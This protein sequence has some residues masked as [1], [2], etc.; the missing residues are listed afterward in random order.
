MDTFL[1]IAEEAA[2]NAGGQYRRSI[3]EFTGSHWR[4]NSNALKEHST[5]DFQDDQ[6]KRIFKSYITGRNGNMKIWNTTK[7]VW[8]ESARIRW[9]EYRTDNDMR[10]LLPFKAMLA[11]LKGLDYY[12]EGQKCLIR[13]IQF[14]LVIT[15]TTTR[16][17]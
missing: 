10:M 2:T 12:W 1:H 9:E 3:S 13:D 15:H 16:E 4:P 6:G 11:S 8:H 17:R 14:D 7:Q 5:L